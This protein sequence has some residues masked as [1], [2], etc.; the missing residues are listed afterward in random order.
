MGND[1]SRGAAEQA[2]RQMT[3]EANA[4][5]LGQGSGGATVVVN[6]STAA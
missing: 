2:R 3:A 6:D 5:V 1:Q 4:A